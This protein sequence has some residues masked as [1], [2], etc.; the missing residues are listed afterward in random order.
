M[1]SNNSNNS[2]TNNGEYASFT[3]KIVYTEQVVTLNIPT[4]LCIANFIEH[5]KYKVQNAFNID[6]NLNIEIVEAG[7]GGDGIRG[8]EAPAITFDL[9]TTIR[10][11]YNGVYNSVAY[12]IRIL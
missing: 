10:E 3:F 11:K 1:S 2:N 5:V 8:E 4:N 6:R 7:Q 9:N 12:Y